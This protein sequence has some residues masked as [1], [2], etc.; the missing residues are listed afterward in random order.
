MDF[1]TWPDAFVNR[2]SG[3]MFGVSLR[4]EKMYYKILTVSSREKMGMIEAPRIFG[5]YLFGSLWLEQKNL[6]R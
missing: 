4:I 2:K 5:T 1:W 3:L 6:Q